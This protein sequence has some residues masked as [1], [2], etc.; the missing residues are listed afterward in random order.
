MTM[1][2]VV[3]GILAAGLTAC[4]ADTSRRT[5]RDAETV[6]V[7]QLSGNST[8]AEAATAL[9]LP[10][11]FVELKFDD[12]PRGTSTQTIGGYSFTL[13]VRPDGTFFDWTATGGVDFVIAKGG[14]AANVYVYD[15]EAT[16]GTGLV[17]PVNASG[18]NAALSHASFCFDFEVI[19]AKT[20]ATSLTRTWSWNVAKTA[21]QS[22]LTLST[23]QIFTVNYTVA[24]SST[25][26]DSDW[27]ASGDITITNP[28]PASLGNAAAWTGAAVLT[29]VTDTVSDGIVAP[30]DCG[31]VFPYTLPAGGSLSCSY[32][33][34]LPDAASR[35][36]VA[37][38]AADATSDVGGGSGSAA[39]DFAAA[40]VRKNDACVE[41]SDSLAGFL[42]EVC[43]GSHTF[44]Y[45]LA[46]GPFATCGTYSVEN[47]AWWAYPDRSPGGTS[48][49]VVPV[50]VPCATGCTLTQGYWKTHGLSGPAPYDDAWLLVGPAGASTAFGVSGQ[51]WYQV[52]WTAPAGNPW[53]VLAHQYAA[54]KLNVLNGADGAAIASTLA[55]ADAFFATTPASGI[56]RQNR[57]AVLSA[58]AT[59]DQFNRGLI[60]P[61]HCSE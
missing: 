6:P 20:A 45:P 14:N 2:E 31:V 61:G 18:G 52:L 42:G 47:V 36:N 11:H 38:A 44:T 58:A 41:V 39:V 10:G 46:V 40:G 7:Y 27:A 9:D 60:G 35:T 13:A 59:L 1:R 54:A 3:L 34:P 24:A 51:T 4:S 57:A 33:V 48:T 17:S 26:A 32:A 53:Y 30:V 49:Y 8:C 15:P 16:S 21:D 29:G 43:E 56:T 55:W 28:A 25:S 50:D 23:G 19:V 37:V 5:S 12:D 22:A